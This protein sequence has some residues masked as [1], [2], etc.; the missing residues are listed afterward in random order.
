MSVWTCM[1]IKGHSLTLVQSHSYSTLSNFFSLETAGPI[2]AKF[3]VEP[4]WDEEIKGCSN[5]LGHMTN[6]ATMS[7]YGKNLKKIFSG[8][9]RLMTLKVGMQHWVLKYY[10]VCSIDDPRLTLTLFHGHDKFGPLCFYM[11]KKVKQWIFQN[12]CSLW[13]MF[14][15]GPGHMTKMAMRPR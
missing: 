13:W 8:T 9:K 11:G 3:H 10:E 4:P 6:M 15:H 7:I 14:V 2:E 1:N 5:S 12:Y